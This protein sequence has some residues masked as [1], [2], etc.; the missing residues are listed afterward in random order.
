MNAIK[1]TQKGRI[2]IYVK[3]FNGG[4]SVAVT[5]SG[6]GIN[7]ADLFKICKL[8]QGI[9]VDSNSKENGVGFG[10]TLA[11]YIAN[12]LGGSGL[13]VSSKINVGSKFTF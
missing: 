12:L 3:T 13:E 6:V 2:K 5:D 1:F 7:T 8:Y 4:I 10:L 11:N 9:N